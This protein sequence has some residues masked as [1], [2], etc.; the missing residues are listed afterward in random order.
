VA[1]A[2]RNPQASRAGLQVA[3]PDTAAPFLSVTGLTKQYGTNPPVLQDL[4]L[5]AGE[6]EFLSLL[7]ASGCGKSTLLRAIAGLS[8]VSS[9]SIRID[10]RSPQAAR[11]NMSFVFQDA[12]LLPWRTAA[13]NVEL[14]LE[15]EGIP[16]PQRQARVEAV[17]QQVGLSTVRDFYPRQLSG[18]MKMRVSIARALATTPQLLL[19]DEPFGALDELTRQRLNEELLALRQ[20]Q[21]CT[22][23]FV[24]HSIS[25]AVFLSDRILLMGANPGR[26]CEEIAVALPP[27]RTA[28]L[29]S[30]TDFLQ[31][32][33]Q[34]GRRL[35]GLVP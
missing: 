33:A 15:L 16:R 32:V 5:V 12:T 27:K 6:G 24:T 22:T 8:S 26:V 30:E 9:G 7:G 11:E 19:M 4:S 35:A 2:Q 1:T 20:R 3:A 10:G 23:L 13:R 25:E 28:E 21:R 31:L 34:V 14:A 18:G 17:L 29:R